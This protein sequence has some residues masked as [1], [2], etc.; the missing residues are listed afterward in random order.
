MQKMKKRA[1][2]FVSV[3]AL[4]SLVF[5][6]SATALPQAAKAA[7]EDFAVGFNYENSYGTEGLTTD[8]ELVVADNNQAGTHGEITVTYQIDFSGNLYS[9]PI[10]PASSGD[11]T[12]NGFYTS[13]GTITIPA[14]QNS[15]FVQIQNV[16][17]TFA[18]QEESF[19]ITILDAQ[20]SGGDTV[21]VA[22]AGGAADMP[23]P[24]HMH[25]I[26]D[27]DNPELSVADSSQGG[28]TFALED[29]GQG[30]FKVLLSTI[31]T[32][33]ITFDWSVQDNTATYL[34]DYSIAGGS[35][36]IPAGETSTTLSIGVL[37]DDLNENNEEIVSIILS[38]PTNAVLG[39]NYARI[40][41]IIDNEDI[42]VGFSTNSG[43]GL[44]NVGTVPLTINLNFVSNNEV[45][46]DISIE[47]PGSSPA[48]TPSDFVL[49]NSSVVFPAGTT[50]TVV[51]LII[52][53]DNLQES[54][55]FIWLVI[56]NQTNGGDIIGVGP[57]SSFGYT[58]QDNGDVN[59]TPTLNLSAATA[60]GMENEPG[61]FTVS[62][63][64]VSTEN[65]TF[66]W[67]TDGGTA[68]IVPTTVG[69]TVFPADY[70]GSATFATATI[71]AGS[72]S[73]T[74]SLNVSDDSLAEQDETFEITIAS[75]SGA[76]IGPVNTQTYT[77]N[78]NDFV[79]AQFESAA[80]SGSESTGSANLN[81]V[82]SNVS[83][84]EVKVYVE[85]TAS[86]TATF[87]TEWQMAS[88][89]VVFAPGETSKPIGLTIVDDGDQESSETAVVAL[90]GSSIGGVSGILTHTYTI[91]DNDTPS[92]S[93]GGS[94]GSG[95]GGGGGSGIAL[96]TTPT[97]SGFAGEA[98]SVRVES[99]TT[100]GDTNFANLVLAGGT[101]VRMAI[102]NSLGF[103]NAVS[104]S[105]KTS[106]IWKLSSG[107]GTKTVYV[108]FFN[109]AGFASAIVSTTVTVGG[110]IGGGEVLGV[111][112]SLLDE[113]I[114]KLKAGTTSDE[115]RQ[116]QV[117]LQ[118]KGYFTKN[119]R[120]TRF[121]GAM[122][123]A[124]VA[125][126][127]ADKMTVD[128]LVAALKLG[129]RGALVSK[130][131]TELKKLGFFPANMAATGYFGLVTKASVT[132]YLASKN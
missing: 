86:S 51:N 21:R 122:T 63:D 88:G 124:A 46:A 39:S 12:V 24:S 4:A 69:T 106:A 32:S 104:E 27:N 59:N 96:P 78:E 37:D 80:S 121:Y 74:I 129:N 18:E 130:L 43:S 25:F 103:E 53:D 35:A 94:G 47:E 126:Y 41:Y 16:N 66:Q 132:K 98:Q 33:D 34:E 29:Q 105:Y 54:D 57:N 84:R 6:L 70:T 99:V 67:K 19:V 72:L 107:A 45:T 73:T 2:Q 23:Y 89:T 55:E 64:A 127:L 117:E 110:S 7:G 20:I 71:P 85:N 125:R 30:T 10:T 92:G 44:E 58:I 91:T 112:I 81:I 101:A 28:N 3:L 75:A 17:D 128:E 68:S 76:T 1:Q 109:N 116:L 120:P 111:Q 93:G 87:G 38:N 62:M 22:R 97:G 114:A 95:G 49:E 36:T 61:T 15:V 82:L 119:F 31:S 90:T 115:V 118:K 83:D 48:S 77:I 50:S 8:I 5:G 113:L 26:V 65:V 56:R 102:S 13:S 52:V 11:F 14:D 131:Q 42:K 123:R 100:V 79:N 9:N 40:Y 108:K 60:S